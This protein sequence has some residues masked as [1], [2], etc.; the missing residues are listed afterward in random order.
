MVTK[1]TWFTLVAVTL[2]ACRAADPPPPAGR[3]SLNFVV[4]SGADAE[5]RLGNGT[6]RTIGIANGS[7]LV[8]GFDFWI[9]CKGAVL[10]SHPSDHGRSERVTLSPGESMHV[11]ITGEFEKDGRCRVSLKLRDGTH[12]DSN[13]FQP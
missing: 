13:E 8:S 6:S 9:V 4:I 10:N 2:A 5:F 11:F 12:V 7:S 3:V 1:I